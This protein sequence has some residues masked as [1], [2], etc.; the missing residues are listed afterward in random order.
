MFKPGDL[1]RIHDPDDRIGLAHGTVGLILEGV[2]FQA[3]PFSNQYSVLIGEEVTI[4]HEEWLRRYE[5]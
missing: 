3:F 2:K 4:V 5:L 1:I